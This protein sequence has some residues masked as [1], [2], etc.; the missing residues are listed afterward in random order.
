MKKTTAYII[1]IIVMVI[2][3]VG[4]I[5]W[6]SSR[7]PQSDSLFPDATPAVVSSPKPDRPSIIQIEKEVTSEMIR[8]GLQDVG[9]L[10]TEEYYF[11]EVVNYSSVK[12]LWNINLGFTNSNFLISYDG[13]VSAGID[14]SD[15]RVEKMDDT[16]RIFVL[17]PEAE[18]MSVEIDFDSFKKY[19]EKEGIGN[20]LTLDN[21]NDALKSIDDMARQKALEKGI[22]IR[23]SENAQFIIQKLVGSLVD[24]NEYSLEIGRIYP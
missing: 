13:V 17:V 21:F 3:I 11:T 8:E 9:R 14:L 10:V 6:S 20:P 22:L 7:F 16:K 1:L 2:L 19:S 23:A 5:L 12:K 15:V 4:V 24:L 18:I